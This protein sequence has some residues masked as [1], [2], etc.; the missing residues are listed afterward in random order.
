MRPSLKEN[1]LD[2]VVDFANKNEE[3][4]WFSELR[5]DALNK[6]ADLAL[7]QYEKINYR[8]WRLDRPKAPFAEDENISDV[9]LPETDNLLV[10]NGGT[11][12]VSKLSDKL[13]DKGVIFTDIWTALKEYPDLVQKYFLNTTINVDSN[14]LI[15]LNLALMNGGSF[16]YIPKNLKVEEAIQA[17]YIQNGDEKKDY[18]HHVLVVAD[19][20]SEVTYLENYLSNGN[21]ETNIAN[22]VVEVVALDNS[23]VHFSALDQFGSNVSTY[24]NRHGYVGNDARLDW[25][26]GSMNDGHVVGDFGTELR[27]EGSHTEAKVVAITTSDQV[28]G[29][30]TKVTNYGKHSIGHILQHGVI[31]QSSTLTFNG[32]GHIVKGARG[33]DSQQESRVLMLSRKARGDA[34]PI[35]LIDENDVTAGHAASVGRVN[36][37]QMYYLMSRGIDEKTAQ[38]LVIRGFLSSVI[39]E[40]PEKEVRDRMT[41]MI[42]RKLVNGQQK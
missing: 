16:L 23:N 6:S 4:N 14:K 32:V 24:L 25:A 39:T 42:E 1:Y 41:A 2:Q 19:E 30:D 29:I 20:G 7:P 18:N 35:L 31:L 13:A 33:S 8:S 15:A 17:I 34:D 9:T 26:I 27:G 38:R 12:V 22:I 21:K 37:D 11:T 3:P 40:I 5:Q 10:Q 28:Q 36:E